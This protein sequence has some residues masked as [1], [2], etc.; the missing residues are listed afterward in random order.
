M[1]CFS[2]LEL[3]QLSDF[4]FWEHPLLNVIRGL[5]F[6]SLCIL[7]MNTDNGKCRLKDSTF[8]EGTRKR[9]GLGLTVGGKRTLSAT[10]NCYTIKGIV[11]LLLPQKTLSD[12]T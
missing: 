2:F 7:E 11:C 4:D 5:H 6:S 1:T 10:K 9:P 12:F 3:E 8:H